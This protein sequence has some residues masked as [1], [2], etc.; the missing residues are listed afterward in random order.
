MKPVWDDDLRL[1]DR[2]IPAFWRYGFYAVFAFALI[3]WI[4]YPSWPIANTV[5]PGLATVVY[6]D[7]HGQPVTVPWSARAVGLRDNRLAEQAR[8]ADLAGLQRHASAAGHA[9]DERHYRFVMASGK[10]LF[11]THCAACHPMVKFIQQTSLFPDNCAACHR[12][13][14]R[15]Q[16]APPSP[17]AERWIYG[18]G[19]E[20]IETSIRAGRRS[21]MPGYDRVLAADQ[22]ADLAHYILSLSGH[23]VERDRAMRGDAL[24][25][26]REAACHYCHGEGGRGRQDIGAANLAD[27]TWLWTRVPVA[28]D[29]A[30]KVRAITTVI[31][32]GLAHNMPAWEKRLSAD[33]IKLLALYVHER[34][35]MRPPA[36]AAGMD[37]PFDAAAPATHPR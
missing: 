32:D 29:L 15:Q 21:Y 10:S 22:Q 30:G 35:S 24:F 16:V 34:G 9:D 2:P 14:I 26:S 5:W 19:L 23:A 36:T 33:E 17:G 20:T 6:P 12:A 13:G 18:G 31:G 8:Q 1:A 11:A 37:R 4:L 27:H 3:Y 25:H 28:P 7:A